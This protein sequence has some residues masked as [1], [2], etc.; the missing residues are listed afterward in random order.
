M[1]ARVGAMRCMVTM[2]KNQVVGVEA[3]SMLSRIIPDGLIDA[4]LACPPVEAV[5]LF[6]SDHETPEI[7][8]GSSMR[9]LLR[10]ELIPVLDSYIQRGEADDFVFPTSYWRVV[11]PEL[12]GELRV[13]G[14]YVR[15]FLKNPN[16]QLKDPMRFLE[17]LTA[18]ALRRIEYSLP[19]EA[20][21]SGRQGPPPPTPGDNSNALVV[22]EED[23]LSVLV[24]AAVYV[25]RV[26]P[27]LAERSV[28]WGH[29]SRCATL[30]KGSNDASVTL[31]GGAGLA[32]LRLLHQLMESP[33]AVDAAATVP[34][35]NLLVEFRRG[36][37]QDGKGYPPDSA[38]ILEAMAKVVCSECRPQSLKALLST[39]IA[40]GL[41]VWLLKVLEDKEDKLSD[42]R[43]PEAARVHIIQILKTL[44]AHPE[45][46][47][48][49]NSVLE[50]NESWEQYTG[51]RQELYLTAEHRV[52]YFLTNDS[53]K[54]ESLLLIAN[55]DSKEGVPASAGTPKKAAPEP[56][57]KAAGPPS[58]RSAPLRTENA[59]ADV[60]ADL[61][62]DIDA[63]VGAAQEKAVAS[64]A[65]E[66]KEAGA[67]TAAANPVAAVKAPGEQAA[68]VLRGSPPSP[69]PAG[70][71]RIETFVRK[72]S[73]GFGMDLAV[74]QGRLRIKRIKSG[75]SNPAR[76]ADPPLQEGD[77]I[78]LINGESYTTAKEA[79]SKIRTSDG[80]GL[81]LCVIR[82]VD[83][84]PS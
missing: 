77:E 18:E 15:L 57:S 44:A 41:I 23:M 58:S 56:T 17:H 11:Y 82:T 27:G 37:E 65:P 84:P 70:P 49:V 67:T 4:V 20:G 45:I 83:A 32:V 73:D 64:R 80:E 43:D 51:Q 63:D 74:V 60:D 3:A 68:T 52:D 46:G 21:G 9:A 31:G 38:F 24:S 81:H 10:R 2:L 50:K 12:R 75:A 6:D 39:A 28:Q 35:A 72:S 71:V 54:V 47:A 5:N 78:D 29:V 79:V 22:R 59:A 42:I 69:P 34:H 48:H 62:G 13:G 33:S 7:I 1:Y 26:R 53:H 55:E 40:D 16:F 8:W 30:L 36:I 61:D 76:L 66:G 19:R 14:V 25:L